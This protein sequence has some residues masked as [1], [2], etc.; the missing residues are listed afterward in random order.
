MPF[1]VFMIVVS[2]E[3]FVR[4]LSGDH[5]RLLTAIELNGMSQ[6]DYATAN[7]IPYSTLKSRVKKARGELRQVF[8][9]CCHMRLDKQGNLIDYDVKD[10]KHESC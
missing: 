10:D 2:I 3:P 4:V 1:I 8:D 5:A 9:D 6:K 7:G